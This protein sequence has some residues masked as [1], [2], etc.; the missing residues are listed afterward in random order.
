MLTI[1]D[2]RTTPF[3]LPLRSPLKW[4]VHS[5][6][7]E[8]HHVLVEVVLS[9]GAIGT[10]E[11][12][13]RPTIYGETPWG[14]CAVIEHELKP[15]ITGTV[16]DPSHIFPLLQ[17]IKNNQ[18][19][20]SAIDVALY[21]ALAQSTGQ[22][23]AQYLGCT[24]ESVRVSYILGIAADDEMMADAEWVVGQGVRV[25]K[26]KVGRDWPADLRRLDL[27][28]KAF[29]DTVDLYTDANETMDSEN[30]VDRLKQLRDLGILYCEEPLPISQLVQRAHLKAGEYLPI[31]GDDSCFAIHD[32]ERELMANTIDI[33]NI[34]SARTGYTMSR[35]MLDLAVKH[36]KGIMIGSHAASALGAARSGL[37]AALAPVEHPSEL[38]FFLKMKEEIVANRP[39][40]IDGQILVDDLL[41]VQI[42]RDLLRSAAIA[43]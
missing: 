35:Q 19:A 37:F 26:V 39:P 6:L 38:T 25:L 14:I 5:I 24:R 43:Y 10:A 21:D 27:L 9:N 42:D 18:T 15:R 17:Q 30:A 13:P 11:A 2:I 28:K 32:V 40:I 1:T 36:G 7:T 4:G 22:S 29:G 8:A 41:N 20:K 31:I 34:K 3:Q 12:L 23:L 33:L 16:A